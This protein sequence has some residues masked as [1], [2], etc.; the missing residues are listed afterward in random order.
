MPIRELI[1]QIE[2]LDPA[3]PNYATELVERVLAASSQA[4]ASDAH[5]QPG[6]LGLELKFRVDGVLLPVATL[7]VKLAPNIVARLKVL[8]D[9]LTYRTD[10]PQEGRI[11]AGEGE[12]EMRLCTFPTLF[13]ERAVVRLFADPDR[14]LSVADLGLP[15][16]A[17]RALTDALGTTTGAVVIAGPAGSG[18][19]TTLYA[20]LR[21]L[22]VRS[23]GTRSLVTL[24]DPIEA[25][26]PGVAQSQVNSAAGLTLESGL[27][28]MLRQDPEVIAIGEIRDSATATVALQAALTG[29]LILTTFH[30][31]GACEVISRLLDMGLEPYAIRSGLR[32][33]LGLRL[34]RRL[35][36]CSRPAQ[37][38]RD[39]LGMDVQ[40]ARIPNGCQ[41]CALTGYTG[42][43]VLAEL[44][45]PEHEEVARAI[46]A[47]ADVRKLEQAAAAAG[48]IDFRRRSREAVEQGL[49]SPAEICRVLGTSRTIQQP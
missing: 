29:H 20:C 10:I 22:S 24:E 23:E 18:K 46:L 30:A 42:R 39:L 21:E 2:K 43:T 4:R 17:A 45:N 48:F 41:R 12:I 25:V 5:F 11:R 38:E 40:Q 16:D 27:K 14:F 31:G 26:I 7:P 36:D 37:C 47:R 15:G 32:T 28:S 3:H 35:C 33:I 9:L 19:T 44:L 1:Q 13:G 8:A 49:T 34:V 6:P